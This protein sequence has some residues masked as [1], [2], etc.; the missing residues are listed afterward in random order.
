MEVSHRI[1]CAWQAYA[2]HRSALLDHNIPVKLRARLFEATVSPCALFGLAS[3]TLTRADIK[4]IG[5]TQRKMLQLSLPDSEL[6]VAGYMGVPP[7]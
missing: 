6:F 4:Q 3:L 5:A 1:A 2:K 7:L